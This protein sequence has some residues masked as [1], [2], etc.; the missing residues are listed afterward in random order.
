MQMCMELPPK[1]CG[2]QGLKGYSDPWYF[3]YFQPCSSCAAAAVRVFELG[4]VRGREGGIWRLRG[5]S[6][7]TLGAHTRGKGKVLLKW[8][9]HAARTDQLRGNNSMRLM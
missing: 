5:E 7:G 3:P 8:M 4:A 6:S 1:V 9:E 2:L